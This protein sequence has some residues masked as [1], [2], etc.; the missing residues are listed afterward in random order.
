MNNFNLYCMVLLAIGGLLETWGWIT[1]RDPKEV[2]N[3]QLWA[4]IL[5]FAAFV[6]GQDTQINTLAAKVEKLEKLEGNK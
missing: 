5:F 2:N 6:L 1:A 4:T 3:H